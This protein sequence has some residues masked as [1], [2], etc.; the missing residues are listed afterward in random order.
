MLNVPTYGC[1]RPVPSVYACGI[2]ADSKKKVRGGHAFSGVCAFIMVV[3]DSGESYSKVN[4]L[5]PK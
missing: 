1:C 4:V 3:D 5:I 2:E